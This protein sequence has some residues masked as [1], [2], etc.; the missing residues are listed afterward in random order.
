M[1]FELEHGLLKNRCFKRSNSY[2]DET[3]LRIVA[4]VRIYEINRLKEEVR[5]KEDILLNIDTEIEILLID[6]Q[7][8]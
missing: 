8:E 2:E 3:E 4:K 5:N 1:K 7:Y 6:L